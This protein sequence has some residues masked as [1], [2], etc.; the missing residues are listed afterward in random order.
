[1][2]HEVEFFPPAFRPDI[3]GGGL[4]TYDSVEYFFGVFDGQSTFLALIRHF[5]P[6]QGKFVVTLFVPFFNYFV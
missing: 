6:Y 5:L 4:G 1:V 2:F 3:A